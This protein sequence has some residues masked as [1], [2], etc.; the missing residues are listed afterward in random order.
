MLQPGDPNTYTVERTIDIAAPAPS[1]YELLADFHRWVDW[2]P[3]EGMDPAMVRTYEGPD[4]GVGGSYAWEGNRK[5]GKGR[6][7]IVDAVPTERVDVD[8]EFIKP[9]KSR[10]FTRF[11]LAPDGDA[12]HGDLDHGRAEDPDDEGD[13]GLREHGQDGR[14]G[15]RQGPVP[16]EV[17]GRALTGAMGPAGHPR[18]SLR[19]ARRDRGPR[20][21]RHADG[22]GDAHPARRAPAAPSRCRTTCCCRC[23]SCRSRRRPAPTPR[24]GRTWSWRTASR[25]PDLARLYRVLYRTFNPI[26]ERMARGDEQALRNMRPGQWQAEHFEDLPVFVIPCYRRNLKHRPVGRPQISVAS[27]YGSVFPA[28]QNLLLGCRAVGLGASHPD[29]ADLV[30]AGGPA[31]PRP[32]PHGQPRVH[33]PDRLGQGALRPDAAPPDR[34]GRP[35]RPL[36]QPAV[37]VPTARAAAPWSGQGRDAARATTV[38]H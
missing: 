29:A 20:P 22:R 5:V 23:S 9:F 38:R 19:A 15:F 36:R 37:R 21:A 14:Q 27:F 8:L 11:A 33:H 31:D 25:R 13:G 2:S 26:V 28:V 16:T 32:A 34:R 10:N 35:P 12:D 17:P 7:E 4:S 1:V 3:W 30:R 18:R 24:T 6:M